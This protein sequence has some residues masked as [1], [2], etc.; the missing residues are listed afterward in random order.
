[1]TPRPA[2]PTEN[3]PVQG[4]SPGPA[5]RRFRN[6][7]LRSTRNRSA[8]KSN[9]HAVDLILMDFLMPGI[10]GVVATRHIKNPD[11]LRDIPIIVVTAK[12]AL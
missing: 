3:D 7:S 11:A 4:R 5:H 8:P 12:T 9:P 1:M 10:D 6:R 2:T